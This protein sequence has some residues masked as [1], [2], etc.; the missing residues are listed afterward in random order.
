MAETYVPRAHLSQG[1][2]L[3]FAA[4]SQRLALRRSTAIRQADSLPDVMQPN[5]AYLLPVGHSISGYG[6]GYQSKSF[7][8]HSRKI[9]QY[10]T[11]A[12]ADLERSQ[13]TSQDQFEIHDLD[14]QL[15]GELRQQLQCYP[16]T[17]AELVKKTLRF[18]PEQPLYV[19]LVS[20]GAVSAKHP[21]PPLESTLG[22]QIAQELCF[23][24][25]LLVCL[26]GETEPCLVERIQAQSPGNLLDAVDSL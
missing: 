18:F 24:R 8:L 9:N 5:L 12:E 20:P 14:G 11:L 7:P 10:R 22:T 4:A 25:E 2:S 6:R 23:R 17:G 16:I 26:M 1:N 15:L 21:A 13:L 19:L 3:G